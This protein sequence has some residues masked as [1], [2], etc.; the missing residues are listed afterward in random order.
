[1]NEFHDPNNNNNNN[2]GIGKENN[3]NNNNKMSYEIRYSLNEFH[4]LPNSYAQNL[5][6]SGKNCK[7]KN[8]KYEIY[9]SIVN[10]KFLVN[11]KKSN[12]KLF[13]LLYDRKM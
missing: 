9:R 4:D 6:G 1:M 2:I 3:N 11:V 5:S 12:L 7:I 8:K 13:R 10:T